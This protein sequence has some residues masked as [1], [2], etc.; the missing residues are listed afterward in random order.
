MIDFNVIW[1]NTK[2][3]LTKTV[4][5]HRGLCYGIQIKHDIEDYVMFWIFFG[6][7]AMSTLIFQWVF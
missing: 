7:G 3:F 2:R 5:W 6:F 4:R 1:Y